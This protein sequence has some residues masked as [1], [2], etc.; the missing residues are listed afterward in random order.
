LLRRAGVSGCSAL[1]ARDGRG[2]RFSPR[3]ATP[4]PW[5]NDAADLLRT[6]ALK[7]SQMLLRLLLKLLRSGQSPRKS[8]DFDGSPQLPRKSLN[9][10]R[11][12]R[13]VRSAFAVAQSRSGACPARLGGRSRMLWRKNA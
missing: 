3:S 4:W 5:K 12:L 13:G 6:L 1:S 7:G 10:R 8:Q 9:K 11:G 2:G